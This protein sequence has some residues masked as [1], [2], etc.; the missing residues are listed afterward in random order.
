MSITAA[1]LVTI[2]CSVFLSIVTPLMNFRLYEVDPEHFKRVKVKKFTWLFK[3]LGGKNSMCNDVKNYGII[4]PM[5]IMHIVGYILSITTL[6]LGLI[7]ILIV[8]VTPIIAVI[9]S[10]TILVIMLIALFITVFICYIKS[11]HKD[12]K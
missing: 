5:F 7:L 6:I 4:I 8:N 9:I 3:G 2:L 12:N 1:I 10:C 11:K